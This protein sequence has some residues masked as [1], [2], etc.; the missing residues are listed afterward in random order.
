MMIR[1][2]CYYKLWIVSVLVGWSEVKSLSG[3]WL[4]DPM[5]CSLPGFSIHGIFQE[6]VLEWVAITFSRGFSWPR[7]WTQVS[8]IAGRCFTIWA[9]KETLRKLK[10]IQKKWRA[11]ALGLE[12]SIL[13]RWSYY[14]KHSCQ[15]THDIFHINKIIL[16]FL[17][18]YKG[19]RIAK[20]N[21]EE[22]KKKEQK[23]RH[24]PVSDFR[25]YHKVTVIKTM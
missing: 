2:P 3:V 4:C 6:R 24:N 21:L 15:I 20:A 17:R 19:P 11:H 12:E 5:D 10:T 22:K 1:I 18:N 13:W 7:D 8:C 23:R 25:Q 16:N 9:T 14:P